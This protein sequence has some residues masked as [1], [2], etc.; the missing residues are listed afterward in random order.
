M[1]VLVVR[2]VSS[3]M[4]SLIN[5]GEKPFYFL[6]FQTTGADEHQIPQPA[7]PTHRLCIILCAA[8]VDMIRTPRV[9]WI[10]TTNIVISLSHPK[11]R[12]IMTSY[13]PHHTWINL[14]DP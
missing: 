4:Y 6:T 9:Q 12:V 2:I 5:K 14:C 1:A 7:S 10:P 8:Q 11:D 13:S 3:G